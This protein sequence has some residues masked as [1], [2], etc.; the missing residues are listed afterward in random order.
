MDKRCLHCNEVMD[1]ERE[2]YVGVC[3]RCRR[4]GLLT[5]KFPTSLEE[6]KRWELKA[7][8]PTAS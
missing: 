7:T 6:R 4:F 3:T 2:R 8:D 1:Q 5:G